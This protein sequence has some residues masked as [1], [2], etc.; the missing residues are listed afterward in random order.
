MF[1]RAGVFTI[2]ATVTDAQ[3]ITGT[4]PSVVNVTEQSSIAVT[5]GATPNPVSIGNTAQQGI[6][7]FTAGAGGLGGGG[8]TASSFTWDFGDGQSAFT[9]GASTNHR[10]TAPGTY[11][12]TVTARTAAGN[13]GVGQLTVRVNP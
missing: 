6:V 10:Y 3:G 4:S 2:R 12:A 7:N 8:A 11:I 9:T 5:L 1:P 13:T